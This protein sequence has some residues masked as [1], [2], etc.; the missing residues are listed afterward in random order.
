M[1]TT[2]THQQSTTL[3]LLAVPGHRRVVL[4]PFW[5]TAPGTPLGLNRVHRG[6]LL[7]LGLGAIEYSRG[8]PPQVRRKAARPPLPQLTP[9]AGPDV[10]A[11]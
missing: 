6:F 10:T 8:L 3:L 11:N 9:A 4:Y 5:T 7:N 1:T 2:I